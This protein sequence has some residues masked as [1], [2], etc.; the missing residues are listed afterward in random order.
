M[1]RFRNVAS[2]CGILRGR[3]TPRLGICQDETLETARPAVYHSRVF[4]PAQSNYSVH[5][6]ELLALQDL[7]KSYEHWL[8]GRPFI[9]VTDSQPMLELLKQ[10]YLS[11]RQMRTVLYLSKF[12]ITWEFVPGKKNIIA[13]LLSRVAERSTYRHD[14][15]VLEEDDSHLAAIQLRRGKVL[16]EMPAPKKRQAKKQP[17][18]VVVNQPS[19]DSNSASFNS[20]DDSTPPPPLPSDDQ[21][22]AISLSQFIPTIVEGYKSDMQFSKALTA[23]IESGIYVLESNGLLYLAMPGAHRVCIPNIKVGEKGS[24][25]RELLI[26]HVHEMIAHKGSGPTSKLLQLQLLEDNVVRC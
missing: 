4:N 2:I 6:Q 24:N 23:G 9:T 17:S 20:I 5:E 21:M 7:I 16:L 15:P 10:K 8:I 26:L 25:L 3:D 11:H 22:S 1:W 19:E 13:D 14:L 18:T 12:D